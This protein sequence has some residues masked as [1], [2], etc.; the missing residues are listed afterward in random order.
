MVNVALTGWSFPFPGGNSTTDLTIQSNGCIYLANLVDSS[1]DA[2]GSAY[3]SLAPFRDLPARICPFFADMDPTVGGGIYF[4][5]N[6]SVPGSEWARITW[7]HVPEWPAVAGFDNTIQV[8]L[9]ASGLVEIVTGGL[10]NRSTTYGNNAVVGFSIGNGT[11]LPTG[12]INYVNA[13]ATGYPTGDGA[14]PPILSMDARP[15]RGTTPNLIT[16]NITPGTNF[17]FFVATLQGTTPQPLAAFGMPDCFSHVNYLPGSL[18]GSFLTGINAQNEFSVPF[19]IPAAAG[20]QGVQFFFQC[21]PL[22][23]GL[24]AAGIL[25]SNGLCVKIGQ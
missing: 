5:E 1:Y 22:T 15:V 14:I 18:V 23:S 25:T 2:C 21:A 11:R 24:N 6:T 4:E 8:T 20:Y 19:P 9:H 17:A 7:D 16:S 13:V 3:G 12:P 10:T